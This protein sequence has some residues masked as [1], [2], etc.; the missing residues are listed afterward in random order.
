VLRKCLEKVSNSLLR[1]SVMKVS[2]KTLSPRSSAEHPNCIKRVQNWGQS[3]TLIHPAS[4]IV[5][6][7]PTRRRLLASLEIVDFHLKALH[8]AGGI[9]SGQPC[10]N[11]ILGGRDVGCCE[12]RDPVPL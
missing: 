8:E 11:C 12:H 4:C 1:E 9:Q 5:Q 2:S 3:A 7:L 6:V 10:Q